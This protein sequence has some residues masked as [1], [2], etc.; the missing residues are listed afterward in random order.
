MLDV[1]STLIQQEVIDLLAAG[2]GVEPEVAAI[3]ELAM[4]G[5]L[6][7][8]QALRSRVSLLAGASEQLLKEVSGQLTLTDGVIE[9]IDKVQSGGGK[10]G[11]VS[12]GFHEVLDPLAQQIG[13][14]YHRA[15]RLEIKDGNLT[16]KLL[17]DIIDAAGKARAL[18]EFAADCGAQRTIA[19]G[20]GANDIEMLRAAS[21]AVAFRPKEVLRPYADLIIEENSLK[22]LLDRL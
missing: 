16:G 21:F 13:L 15:N 9:L 14:D 4:N 22:G 19:V 18:L 1:D 7:F 11:V 17:G 20:D 2:Y 3:T 5:Q 12:G 6:D 8:Q 10:I